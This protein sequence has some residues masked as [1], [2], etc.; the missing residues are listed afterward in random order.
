MLTDCAEFRGDMT[1][2]LKLDV[3]FLLT[4]HHTRLPEHVTVACTRYDVSAR[5]VMG[6]VTVP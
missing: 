2:T 5:A 4:E 6:I 3:D 1:N